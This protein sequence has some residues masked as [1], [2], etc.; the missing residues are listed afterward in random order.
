MCPYAATAANVYKAQKSNILLKEKNMGRY[1]AP[2]ELPLNED[3][4]VFHLH[5]KKG[6][7]ADKVILVG[8]PARVNM[9]ASFFDKGSIEC[10]VQS[11]E[12][13]TITGKYNG[14]RVS[15]VSHGIGTDNIDIVLTEL[16]ALVNINFETREVCD[17]LKSLTIVRV[18]TSGG[19]Q[20]FCPIG[21]Y[22]VSKRSIGFDGVLNYY[23]GENVCDLDF[24]DKF[25]KHVGYSARYAR[26]YVISADEKLVE[27]IGYDM[28]KGVTISAPGFS[29]PQ[30]RWVRLQPQDPELNAKI[31]TFDYNGEKITN[32]EMESSAVAGLS[33]LLGHRAMTVCCIIAG[34]TSGDMN[35]EYHGTMEKLV[36]TV[37][38][39]LMK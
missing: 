17:T 3:G 18:G 10:D 22:V 13:H 38:K 31:R 26:P 30:G 33:R 8:D 1:I 39:R 2:S 24:E 37:L 14:Q 5:L 12:F 29:A 7:L 21:S 25:C 15:C 19:M 6:Q 28:I 27:Q 9:V 20:D 35:T 34:R 11:R 23:S 4:S 36:E 16:D 32:Y